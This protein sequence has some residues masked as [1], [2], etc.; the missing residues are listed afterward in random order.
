MA[1]QRF[2][3]TKLWADVWVRKLNP[4][5]RYLF[6]YFL[7]NEHTNI[8]GIYELPL[9][10]MAFETG[11]E[12]DTLSKSMLKRLEPKIFYIEGWVCITNFEKH[13]RGRGNP[14]I[15]QGI[16][17]AK[18][19]VPQGILDNFKKKLDSVS[20]V[21]AYSPNYKD[22]DLDK[23]RDIDREENISP[24]GETPSQ[25]NKNFFL[26]ENN[27]QEKAVEYLS[28]NGFPDISE[29]EIK[30]FVSYWTEPNKSGV[31]QRWELE[32][33]FDI[34]RRLNSWFSRVNSFNPQKNQGRGIA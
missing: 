2:I 25:K 11:I 22:I 31:K 3:N 8:A 1:K 10:N 28:K 17:N 7:T 30:K 13:Q 26:N 18:S 16:E 24:N 5:D 29:Q 33:T 14:K 19:E 15:A 32:K 27:I 23:D 34:K 4:L 6:L 9:E 20:I 12:S 21:Y